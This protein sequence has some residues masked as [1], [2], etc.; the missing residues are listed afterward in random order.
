M[1]SRRCKRRLISGLSVGGSALDVGW[2]GSWRPRGQA[3][4]L[5]EV[6]GCARGHHRRGTCRT[7]RR[8]VVYGSHE[9]R[10]RLVRVAELVAPKGRIVI[11]VVYCDY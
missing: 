9:E 2:W 4:M 8:T 5:C 1:V 11:I 7:Q 6:C 3:S 10:K